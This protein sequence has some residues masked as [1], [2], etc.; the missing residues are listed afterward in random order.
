MAPLYQA[1][2]L[3]EPDLKKL[4][5]EVSEYNKVHGFNDRGYPTSLLRD[6]ITFPNIPMFSAVI[7]DRPATKPMKTL[8]DALSAGIYTAVS[9]KIKDIVHDLEPHIHQFERIDIFTSKSRSQSMEYYAWILGRAKPN[10]VDFDRTDAP[11]TADTN[12]KHV[13]LPVFPTQSERILLYKEAISSGHAWR[14]PEISRAIVVSDE[15]RDRL[16]AAKT[17]GVDF[18]RLGEA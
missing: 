15:L 3:F 8:S 12:G 18:L 7:A 6:G 14:A 17:I 16:V 5:S 1:R 2:L 9:A 13:S 10:V 4:K 11:V